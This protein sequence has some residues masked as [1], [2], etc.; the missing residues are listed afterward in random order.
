MRCSTA[1][2]PVWFAWAV[3]GQHIAAGAP[4][5][6][7]RASDMLALVGGERLFG[8][9]TG[10]SHGGNV[11]I[12]VDRQWFRKHQAD[13]YR[14]TVADD[15]GRRRQVLEQLRVRLTAWRERREEPKLLAN[16]IE[17]SLIQT[18]RKLRALD[19]EKAPLE[20]S[21][22][23][24]V[25]VPRAQVRK[26][27]VQP[28]ATR[29]VLALAWQERL[30]GAEEQTA[31]ALIEQL[32]TR[33]I[34][35]ARVSP[36]LSDRLGALAQDERQWAA[37]VAL[38]EYEI[39][40]KPHYVGTG[41]KLFRDDTG[42]ARPDMTEVLVEQLQDQLGDLLGELLGPNGGAGKPNDENKLKSAVSAAAAEVAA[43]GL[44]C[45]RVSYLSQDPLNHKV[46]VRGSFLARMPDGAWQPIW[47]H[48]STIDATT[49]RANEE[50]QLASDPQVEK[51]LEIAKKFG[52][53]VND[54]RIRTALRYGVVTE[55]ALHD[56][57]RAF[58]E[59]M[60]SNVRRLDGP[61]IVVPDGPDAH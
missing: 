51:V 26:Q 1:I 8:I 60:L 25:E 11:G 22:L 24:L 39:L 33:G 44:N 28:E 30:P 53:D 49:P 41:S 18:E 20:P 59:F 7:D 46:T 57:N 27:Y 2:L 50:A 36:D 14:K 9:L 5:V 47:E 29:R 4:I 58:V 40:G 19:D 48:I 10:P 32:K 52:I 12:V 17:R 56:V 13:L 3:V 23:V 34:D 38:V 16:F 45:L 37:K 15:D 55:E 61:P 21:Q 54:E 42:Q 31:A 43:E 6:Q 35:A